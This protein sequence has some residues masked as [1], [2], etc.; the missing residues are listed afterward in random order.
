MPKSH[1]KYHGID[2][3]QSM[4]AANKQGLTKVSDA[5]AIMVK[6]K[7]DVP[8]ERTGRIY[9]N[10]KGKRVHQAS[11]YGEP[12]A[13]LTRNLQNSIDSYYDD[14]DQAAYTFTDVKYALAL[15]L[16][17]LTRKNPLGKRPYFYPTIMNDHNADL[18]GEIYFHYFEGAMD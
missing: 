2:F 3:M 16:G 10:L 12:P 4:E 9:Y 5:Y 18:L 6:E 7:L 8:P 14:G 17:D 1:F 13:P 11:A 15:E